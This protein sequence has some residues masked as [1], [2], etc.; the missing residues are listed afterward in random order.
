M[1]TIFFSDIENNH[2]LFSSYKRQ[3]IYLD[4]CL[5]ELC[6][7]YWEKHN[8]LAEIDN[9]LSERYLNNE[10]EDALKMFE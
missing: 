6:L 5:Y 2:Y 7:L 1:D 9:L 10:I 4:S 3:L 8:S